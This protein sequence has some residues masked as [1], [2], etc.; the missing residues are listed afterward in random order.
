MSTTQTRIVITRHRHIDITATTPPQTRPSAW[1]ADLWEAIQ[2]GQITLRRARAILAARGERTPEDAGPLVCAECGAQDAAAYVV[3]ILDNAD[4]KN[5][6]TEVCTACDATLRAT[7]LSPGG[8][9]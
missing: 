4:P 2:T 5:T 1:P 6:R 8:T 9:P 3:T 7:A